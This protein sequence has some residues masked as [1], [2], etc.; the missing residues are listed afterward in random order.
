MFL[1]RYLLCVVLLLFGQIHGYK[2]CVETERKALLELKKYLISITKEYKSYSVLLN[3]TYDIK[4][5]CCKWEG[6]ICN[7]TSQRVTE[8][9]FGIYFYF[10]I[11]HTIMSFFLQQNIVLSYNSK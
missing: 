8:I 4:S 1:G 7:Q 5:D 11:S 3:W 2:S 9:A 10:N 6:V